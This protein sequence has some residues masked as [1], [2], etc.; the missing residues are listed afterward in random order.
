MP[1][2]SSLTCS[3]SGKVPP[4]KTG[5]ILFDLA[6][7]PTERVNLAASNPATVAALMAILQPYID[8]AV[9]PLNEMARGRF[10]REIG[11]GP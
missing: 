3:Y 10:A 9:P 2:P 7:D 4:N 11:T 6:A 1:D 8:S 5:A